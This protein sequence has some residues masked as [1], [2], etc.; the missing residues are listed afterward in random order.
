M[1]ISLGERIQAHECLYLGYT[2]IHLR[3]FGS[4][5]ECVYM[6]VQGYAWVGMC[7][8]GGC[9]SVNGNVCVRCT[10][11]CLLVDHVCWGGVYMCL[12]RE[13]ILPFWAC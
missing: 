12:L 8:C 6:Y 2:Y 10:R 9:T 1:C 7:V 5:C 4:V 11:L 13:F 3:I